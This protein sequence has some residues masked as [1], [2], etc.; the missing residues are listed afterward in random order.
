MVPLQTCTTKVGRFGKTVCKAV[1]RLARTLK[2]WPTGI[3]MAELGGR[4]GAR[5]TSSCKTFVLLVTAS[6]MTAARESENTLACKSSFQA[7]GESWMAMWVSSALAT[8]CAF[9]LL[10]SSVS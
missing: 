7:F 4:L 3:A 10:G 2:R 6:M 8:A 9:A 1:N 5:L